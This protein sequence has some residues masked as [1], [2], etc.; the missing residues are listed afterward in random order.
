MPNYGLNAFNIPICFD[1]KALGSVYE[2]LCHHSFSSPAFL[3]DG[4]LSYLPTC[5][6]WHIFD[7]IVYDD[8]DDDSY[9]SDSN[10][11]A[12]YSNDSTYFS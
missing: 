5:F 8:S 1:S 10:I 6:S 7:H 4:L 11:P 12:F 2:L 3:L 9:Y